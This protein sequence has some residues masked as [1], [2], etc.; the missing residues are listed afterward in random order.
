MAHQKIYRANHDLVRKR[1][2]KPSETAQLVQQLARQSGICL[3]L[4]MGVMILGRFPDS[5]LYSRVRTFVVY[6]L[7]FSQYSTTYQTGWLNL[8]PFSHRTPTQERNDHQ[9][10]TVSGREDGFVSADMLRDVLYNIELQHYADGVIIRAEAGAEINS[11]IG[12]Y[13]IGT[14]TDELRG[15][16]HYVQIQTPENQVL[17]VGFLEESVV[18]RGEHIQ[19][20]DKLGVGVLIPDFDENSFYYLAVQGPDG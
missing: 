9:A 8:F 19:V 4:L 10:V 6:D 14:G 11:F 5:A 13:V 7:P 3:C 1:R 2:R 15:I 17:T 20:G 12:G 18:G 16:G